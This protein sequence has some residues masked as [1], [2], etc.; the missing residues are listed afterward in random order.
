MSEKRP[1]DGPVQDWGGPGLAS[2]DHAVLSDVKRLSDVI[3]GYASW[4]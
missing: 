1:T 4:A 2:G 3:T